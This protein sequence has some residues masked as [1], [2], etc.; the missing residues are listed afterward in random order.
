[1]ELSNQMIESILKQIREG[2]SNR[3]IAANHVVSI[4]TVKYL[5]RTYGV[6]QKPSMKKLARKHDDAI[7]KWLDQNATHSVRMQILSNLA[8]R[9]DSTRKVTPGLARVVIELVDKH[10]FPQVAVARGTGLDQSTVG[11]ICR[12]EHG[13][14]KKLAPAKKARPPKAVEPVVQAPPQREVP[15]P[16]TMI[17]TKPG[18]LRRAWRWLFA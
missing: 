10:G 16:I 6:Y 2:R 12:G 1:M 11:F 18:V 8:H 13:V 14:C 9:R 3:D 5:A 17:E 7:A 15:L 4:G